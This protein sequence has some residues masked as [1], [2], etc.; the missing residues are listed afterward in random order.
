MNEKRKPVLLEE[1]DEYMRKLLAERNEHDTPCFISTGDMMMVI[2][3][4]GMGG[5]RVWDCAIKRDLWTGENGCVDSSDW[6]EK[7]TKLHDPDPPIS[8]EVE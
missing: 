5:W 1:R 6:V 3:A 7:G 2:C 8:E 4:D